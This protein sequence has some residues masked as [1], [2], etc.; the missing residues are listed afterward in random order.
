MNYTSFVWSQKLTVAFQYSRADR[1]L[2]KEM[3]YKHNLLILYTVAVLWPLFLY[4]A[5]LP[6]LFLP[7]GKTEDIIGIIYEPSLTYIESFRLLNR[8]LSFIHIPK[9]GGSTLENIGS[10]QAGQSWGKCIFRRSDSCRRHK[11]LPNGLRMPEYPSSWHMPPFFW[12]IGGVLPYEGAD[13]FAVTRHPYDRLVSDHYYECT[14]SRWPCSKPPQS[15]D[16]NFFNDKLRKKLVDGLNYTEDLKTYFRGDGHLIPQYD[17]V[18]GPRNVRMVDYVLQLE[19]ITQQF[20]Y[21]T[22]AYGLKMFL[23]KRT[24]VHKNETIQLS[25]KDLDDG[26]M[27]RMKNLYHADFGMKLYSP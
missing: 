17:Y 13:L 22:Q 3:K 27:E 5:S 24:N 18:V 25:S 9:A 19:N 11:P 7:S 6:P 1:P 8:N 21:L 16:R 4:S 12:P 2:Y 23:G 14:T 20:P 10:S 15:L 26:V